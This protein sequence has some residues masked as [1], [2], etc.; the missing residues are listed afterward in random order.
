ML[1]ASLP[2]WVPALSAVGQT[3][4]LTLLLP[5]NSTEACQKCFSQHGPALLSPDSGKKMISRAPRRKAAQEGD[6]TSP[7]NLVTFERHHALFLC[8]P[9]SFPSKSPQSC[10]GALY[11]EE[12]QLILLGLQMGMQLISWDQQWDPS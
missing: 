2:I 4:L 6:F 3:G 11:Q 9:L 7:Q 12:E 5:A 10:A 1:F 8:F